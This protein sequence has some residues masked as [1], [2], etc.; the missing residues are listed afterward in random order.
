[1]GRRSCATHDWTSF[2]HP[3]PFRGSRTVCAQRVARGRFHDLAQDHAGDYG[4]RPL[5]SAMSAAD[6]GIDRGFAA[7][8]RIPK[9]TRR[10]KSALIRAR[11]ISRLARNLT[12]ARTTRMLAVTAF[13][14]QPHTPANFWAWLPRNWTA[15][16]LP[17]ST[18]S[19]H[20]REVDAA[21]QRLPLPWVR[22]SLESL[23]VLSSSDRG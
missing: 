14:P 18:H 17:Q 7:R 23:L 1:M 15:F 3:T 19:C 5:H 12:S 11:K 21:Q 8:R 10:W 20:G 4:S 22:A 2:S 9:H 6:L 13:S 16:G